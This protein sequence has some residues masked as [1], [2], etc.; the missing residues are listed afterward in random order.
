MQDIVYLCVNLTNAAKSEAEFQENAGDRF[1]LEELS[2]RRGLSLRTISKVLGRYGRC[3]R[4]HLFARA[5]YHLV[6]VGRWVRQKFS[7]SISTS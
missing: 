5:L 3:Q 2:E 1:T 6:K 4:Y 7:V